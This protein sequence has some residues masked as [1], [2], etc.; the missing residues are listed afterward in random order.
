MK[1]KDLSIII[2]NYNTFDLTCNCISS[3]RKSTRHINYEIVIVDNAS[4]NCD[5]NK[6]LKKYPGVRLIKSDLNLGYAKGNNLG[7]TQSSGDNLLILNSDIVFKDDAIQYCHDRLKNDEKIGVIS[8]KLVSPDGS[9][10]FSANRFPSIKKELIELF[11]LQK[12]DSTGTWL[13]GSFFDHNKEVSVDYVWGAFFMTRR[14][15]IDSLPEGKL[16]DSFFMYHEDVEW[17]WNIKQLGLEIIYTPFREVIH[18]GRGS[19]IEQIGMHEELI[20][21]V[22]KNQASFYSKVNGAIKT[23]ILYLLKYLNCIFQSDTSLRGNARYYGEFLRNGLS[24]I[25]QNE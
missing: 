21:L 5:P 17:C 12:F 14:K 10:Q 11:R 22:Q 2:V 6:F 24:V 25:R 16:P 23:Y 18:L 15:V 13:L 8:P 20:R 19:A 4:T 1:K 7:I 9:L 3:V